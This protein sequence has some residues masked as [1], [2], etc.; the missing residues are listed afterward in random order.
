MT[1][2]AIGSLINGAIPFSIGVFATLVGFRAIGKQP[3]VEPRSDEWHQRFGSLF[4]VLG[5]LLMLFGV[6]VW[7]TSIQRTRSDAPQ[8]AH[9]KRYQTSDGVCSAEFPAAPK[10]DTMENLG[11]I[12]NQLT[13]SRSP[14]DIYFMLT[15]SDIS[16]DSPPATEEERLDS[17]RDNMPAVAS[18]GGPQFEFVSEERISESGIL[19]RSLQFAAGESHDFQAKVFIVGTRIYRIIAVT[20]RGNTEDSEVRRFLGS[21]HFEK[22][23]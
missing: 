3:E 5:P 12:S 21:F 4:K 13:L 7:V 8:V 22:H 15:F 1:A 11:V 16:P 6:F 17:I 18:R 19:G 20:P 23:E 9:W 14:R 2:E 10:E